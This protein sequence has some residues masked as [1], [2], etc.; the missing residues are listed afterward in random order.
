MAFPRSDFPPSFLAFLTLFLS[1]SGADS[2]ENELKDGLKAGIAGR[3][4]F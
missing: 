2:V 3:Y 1:P 4:A